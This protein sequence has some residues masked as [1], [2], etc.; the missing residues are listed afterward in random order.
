MGIE[1]VL[2]Y[3]ALG[4]V[5]G[6]MAGLLGIGGG[7]IMVPVL[8]AL[9]AAQGVE[10]SHLVH[11]ALGTSMAAIVITAISS[12]RTHHQHQAVLWPVV[13][14][15]TPAILVGTF[16]ATWLAALLPTRAL[17]IFFSCFMA[18]VSLQMVLNIKPKPHRQLPGVPG[19]SLAGLI[20]G[21]ISALVAIGGG[22]LTV[23]F[24]TWCNVRIQQAIGT[25]A[26]VGLPIALSGAL[27]Y[28]INGWSATGLPAFSVGYVSLPAVVLISA[29]SFFTAPV[30]AR[31]AHRLPVATLKKA[32]AGLLLLL[33]L[34]MLQTVFAG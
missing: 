29:V 7:G 31:L 12:L 30:G 14:R 9:F 23:P 34:K 11:L 33:S 26:A 16:A 5:V 10:T 24:L 18:Y 32:F 2:A 8:T 17:A 15:I 28:V 20:I 13:W 27:G 25:S 3:L 22:S 6:F 19:M 4:A 21:G 1:W